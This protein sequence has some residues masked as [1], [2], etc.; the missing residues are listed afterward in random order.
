MTGGGA[1]VRQQHRSQR[2]RVP[3]RIVFQIESG[4]PVSTILG[5]TPGPRGIARGSKSI[6][7]KSRTLHPRNGILTPPPQH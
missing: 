1:V 7:A 5:E 6:P 3:L 2:S 4:A